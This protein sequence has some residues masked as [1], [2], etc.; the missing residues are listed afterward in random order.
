[1]KIMGIGYNP[2]SLE[3]KR[4]LITGASSGIGQETAV[5]CS[6]MGASVIISARN[7][8]RLMQTFHQLEG[9]DH[10]M[11]PVDLSDFDGV[12]K[13]VDSISK[14]DGLFNN[15]GVTVAKPISFLNEVELGNI[16][17]VNLNAP[18]LLT[19]LLVKKKKITKGG[20]IVFTSSIGR[21]MVAPG[22]SMYAASKGGLSA[23]MKGAALE[24]AAKG[25]RCNAILPGMVETGMMKGKETIS[26][27]QWE[28]NKLL[29]PLKRFGSPREIA[30]LAVYLF[31]DA[32][33]FMTGSE[34]VIDGGRS[35]K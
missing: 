31:S 13:L 1:M 12:R 33:S 11:I 9:T 21:Y 24:L 6:K 8:E 26:S 10:Q 32:S 7:E 34:L 4:I 5:Q 35:L 18:I 22:N 14:I 3:G 17:N 15:A 28:A 29:Y 23:F 20:S 27:E 25:I 16:L 2:F 30:L 19:N